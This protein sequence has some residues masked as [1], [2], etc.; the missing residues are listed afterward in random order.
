[1]SSRL[2]WV[3]LEIKTNWGKNRKISSLGKSHGTIQLPR[4]LTIKGKKVDPKAWLELLSKSSYR[5]G[6][7]GRNHDFF[8]NLVFFPSYQRSN[9]EVAR[10]KLKI[11]NSIWKCW[12]CGHPPTERKKSMF[13]QARCNINNTPGSPT[14]IMSRKK[15]GKRFMQVRQWHSNFY[16]ACQEAQLTQIFTPFLNATELVLLQTSYDN[17]QVLP[18]MQKEVLFKMVQT[19]GRWDNSLV[20]LNQRL[21]GHRLVWRKKRRHWFSSGLDSQGQTMKIERGCGKDISDSG[22]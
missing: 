15:V 22:A 20:A 17:P 19:N 3:Y 8:W 6:K 11:S 13:E 9:S 16:P 1:M 5:V 4:S 2:S 14:M 7:H 12:C 21:P 10:I 18:W